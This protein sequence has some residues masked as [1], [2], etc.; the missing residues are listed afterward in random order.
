MKERMLDMYSKHKTKTSKQQVSSFLVISSRAASV[1]S[2][3]MVFSAL[4]GCRLLNVR[5]G[6]C[7]ARPASEAAAPVPRRSPSSDVAAL[8]DA[9]VPT[10]AFRTSRLRVAETGEPRRPMPCTDDVCLRAPAARSPAQRSVCRGRS[11][12]QYLLQVRTTIVEIVFKQEQ[13]ARETKK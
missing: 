8:G 3:C 4:P 12:Y 2:L 6:L 11:V 1:A 5:D 10:F 13:R 7:G 9:R